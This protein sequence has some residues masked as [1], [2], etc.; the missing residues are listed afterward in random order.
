MRML[1][2]EDDFVSRKLLY[3]YLEPYGEVDVAVDGEEALKAF[4]LA[5]QEKTPYDIVWL[6]IMMPRLDG[7]QALKRIREIEQQLGIAGLARVKT[8]MT[9]ALSDAANVVGS[10]FKEGCDGYITKPYTRERIAAELNKLGM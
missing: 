3:K 10:F 7:R 2:V 6:D 8:I 4:E 5:I 1:I 9:T